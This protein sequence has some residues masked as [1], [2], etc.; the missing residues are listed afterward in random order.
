MQSHDHRKFARLLGS[1]VPVEAV[2][3]EMSVHQVDL[4][5]FHGLG[6]APDPD[7]IKLW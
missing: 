4:V 5:G 1:E 2:S 6:E 7:W 3:K